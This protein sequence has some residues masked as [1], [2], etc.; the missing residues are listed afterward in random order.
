MHTVKTLDLN[1]L[2]ALNALLDERSVTRAAEKLS[3]SQPAMSG[4]LTRLRD[5][6]GDPLF[7]RTQHG[8]LPTDRAK[9][10]ASPVKQILEQADALLRE[11][12]FHPSDA[13]LKIAIAGTDY[14]M[15]TVATP[16]LA[17]LRRQAPNI[18]VAINLL[19]ERTMYDDLERGTLDF[20]LT[21]PEQAP[22]GLHVRSLFDEHYV[23]AL[24][25]DH[26]ALAD[27]TPDLA[28]FCALEHALV[29][30]TG[31]GFSGIADR[32]LAANGVSRRVSLSVQSFL[33]LPDILRDSDLCAVVPYLLVAKQSG[34]TTFAPPVTIP[35][36]TKALA[37][38]ERTHRN[39]AHKWLRDLMFES[40]WRQV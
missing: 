31:S 18:Q 25:S 30:P 7:I 3:V 27:G 37:W 34:I 40:C 14:A 17:A 22:D 23:C 2:K 24:R 13:E 26:P 33:I 15:R 4:M 32:M 1:L 16:F 5:S 6:F 39:P 10:L 20:A 19:N 9:A 38:H 21:T 11:L 28:K 36:F 12:E 29:S 35:G 8:I